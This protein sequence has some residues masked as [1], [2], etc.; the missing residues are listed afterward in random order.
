MKTKI[1]ICLLVVM[2]SLS[3]NAQTPYK[4]SIGGIVG[5]MEG[6]SYKTF[7]SDVFAIQVDFGLHFSHYALGGSVNGN[8]MYEQAIKNGFYWFAGGGLSVG[9]TFGANPF[10]NN[11]VGFRLGL[12]GIGGAEYKFAKIPLTLQADVRPG[13][14]FYIWGGGF[15]PRFDYSLLNASARYTF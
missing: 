14:A 1:I 10:S 6:G 7:I 11:P 8:F 3:L 12:N 9:P 2:S 5:F 15:Y 4:H 13:V